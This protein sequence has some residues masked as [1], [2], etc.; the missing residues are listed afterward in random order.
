MPSQ[1]ATL[2][3][4]SSSVMVADEPVTQ[5]STLIIP[6]AEPAPVGGIGGALGGD[7]GGG[8]V[9][10]AGVVGG[11][12]GVVGGAGVVVGGADGVVGGAGVVVGGAVGAIVVVDTTMMSI[13]NFGV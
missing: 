9:G 1:V 2:T 10:G 12:D 6:F 13:L 8:D 5:T 7:V 3:S 11:A 4:V